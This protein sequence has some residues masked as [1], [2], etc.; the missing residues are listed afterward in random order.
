MKKKKKRTILILHMTK[1]G[2]R[3]VCGAQ[4]CP[5]FFIKLY[6]AIIYATIAM[7]L[8]LIA[9]ISCSLLLYE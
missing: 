3:K 4:L 9:N 1:V 5:Q 6:I 7:C 2:P 8:K